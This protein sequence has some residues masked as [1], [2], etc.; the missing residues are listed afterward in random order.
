MMLLLDSC[1]DGVRMEFLCGMYEAVPQEDVHS[2][3]RF[4]IF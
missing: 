1:V 2:R 4:D 3:E